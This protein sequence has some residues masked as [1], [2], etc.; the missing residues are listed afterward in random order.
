DIDECARAAAANNVICENFGSCV[1]TIGSYHCECIPGTYGFD[2]SQSDLLKASPISSITTA[3]PDDCAISNA[4]VDGVIYPNACIAK[5]LQ[6]KNA[7]CTD[8][9]GT[10]NCTCTE[11]WYGEYC[12]N[13]VN[14][15]EFDPQPCQNFGTCVNTDGYYECVCIPGTEGHDCQINPD[16]CFNVTACNTVDDK[17]NC[18]DGFASFTCTCG[19]DYTMQYCDLELIIYNVLQLIG[20]GSGNE[21]DLINML[22]DLLK[23]PSKM[24]DLIPFVI[25]LQSLENRTRMSFDVEDMF[26]WIAYEEKT[27]DMSKDLVAWNDVVLGNCFTFNHF[28]NTERA[29]LMRSAGAQGGLKAALKLNS[30]EYVPWTET[31][32][33]MTFIHPNTETIFSES[34]RYNAE[35]A[36]MTTIQSLESRYKRL[37]GRYGKCVKSSSEV[38]SYYYEGSYTTDGCLRS[39]YQDEVKKACDC[40]DSRYPMPPAETVC[41]LPDRNCVD[42]ITAKGDVSTWANCE[43]PLPCE[44]SQFDCSYTVAPFVRNRNKCNTYTAEQRLNMTSCD[45]LDGEPDYLIVNVQVPRLVINVFQE[46]PTWTLN[47]IIGN[48]GGLG[49][50]VCGLNLISFFEFAFLLFIQLPAI[51]L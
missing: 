39:C 14:E 24:K 34:P 26:L 38:A 17:A 30:E 12:E 41:E 31:T 23:N 28:N 27:L 29:Y 13:D 33:I 45:D 32:A 19:P 48:V 9:F 2:C 25:G 4:T 22:R 40:M 43:C 1:N 5:Q 42:T 47:R 11:F 18:T 3:D 51:I 36:A 8:G 35:P 15:C 49:G 46:T 10:Y 16:D 7:T 20:G 21:V 6:D 50:V 37:G 44:N